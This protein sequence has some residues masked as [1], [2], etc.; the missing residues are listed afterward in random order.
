V[1]AW[2]E[3]DHR[4]SA[5]AA[6]LT[7]S[8]VDGIVGW[9]NVDALTDELIVERLGEWIATALDVDADAVPELVETKRWEAEAVARLIA[10]RP[11]DTDESRSAEHAAMQQLIDAERDA[12]R[13]ALAERHVTYRVPRKRRPLFLRVFARAR[14]RTRAPRRRTTA[15]SRASASSPGRSNDDEHHRA[16]PG[17]CPGVGVAS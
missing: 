2:E 15:T 17:G 13:R 5:L 3:F 16:R 4:L 11:P 1:S 10:A 9:L 6:E 12:E 7:G 8:H 14:A